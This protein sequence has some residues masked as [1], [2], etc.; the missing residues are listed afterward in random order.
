MEANKDGQSKAKL[1]IP[2]S[3]NDR[4]RRKTF[5]QAVEGKRFLFPEDAKFETAQQHEDEAHLARK[6]ELRHILLVLSP[7]RLGLP[8]LNLLRLSILM[9]LPPPSQPIFFPP[10]PHS[11]QP[12]N[13][14]PSS[15]T[16]SMANSILNYN[17]A[18]KEA[19]STTHP[20]PFSPSEFVGIPDLLSGLRSQ[21]AQQLVMEKLRRAAEA[22]K[23]LEQNLLKQKLE[24]EASP[25]QIP[26]LED[27]DRGAPIIIDTIS[28][29]LDQDPELSTCKDLT[30]LKTDETPTLEGEVG[31]P[32]MDEV[33]VVP[34]DASIDSEA[35]RRDPT[36]N[37]YC[38]SSTPIDSLKAEQ[39]TTQEVGIIMDPFTP[40][41]TNF[42]Q[43]LT[44]THEGFTMV[45]NMKA[46]RKRSPKN[47]KD[48]AS[49]KESLGLEQISEARK[50]RGR[51]C[52]S[53]AFDASNITN[54]EEWP[55]CFEGF[56][57]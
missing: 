47:S 44:D 54:K 13:L 51:P 17:N 40:G 39:S 15:S 29:A 38:T 10:S 46:R 52:S 55:K 32:T 16:P 24:I 31:G 8:P 5:S 11:P 42:E 48:S 23:V 28:R 2:S 9:I 7:S 35:T 34:L 27:M 19:L 56:K 22:R 45:K 36:S 3:E 6:Q 14:P 50:K 12:P 43:G 25:W 21:N 57:S 53:I 18:I 26:D 4:A 33:L 30:G 20:S 41:N 1:V 49:K 37:T